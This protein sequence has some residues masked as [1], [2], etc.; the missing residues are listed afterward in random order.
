MISLTFAWGLVVDTVRRRPSSVT[1][2]TPCICYF[3][4]L[5]DKIMIRMRKRYEN[6]VGT[7]KNETKRK[8]TCG[9]L[10]F[11]VC[12]FWLLIHH[13]NLSNASAFLSL[14]RVRP[15]LHHLRLGLLSS[16]SGI[17]AAL[18]LLLGCFSSEVPPTSLN[19]LRWGRWCCCVNC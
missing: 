6:D 2:G 17:C 19:G 14:S 9:G 15:L 1:A 10:S 4:K 16:A 3:R 8:N 13:L 5:E 18:L 7:C 12:G 11:R